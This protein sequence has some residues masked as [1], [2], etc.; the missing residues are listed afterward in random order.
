MR[1]R[2]RCFETLGDRK[3]I[4]HFW[5]VDFMPCSR[6]RRFNVLFWLPLFRNGNGETVNG[7]GIQVDRSALW[8]LWILP[9]V[10]RA[11]LPDEGRTVREVSC[12]AVEV[13]EGG[14]VLH[15]D[16]TYRV[17]VSAAEKEGGL[18]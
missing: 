11:Q 17:L 10:H 14:P 15:R 8:C 1:K 4:A 13:L 18:R 7:P 5:A 9:R 16:G 3:M 2:T 12:S 6:Y